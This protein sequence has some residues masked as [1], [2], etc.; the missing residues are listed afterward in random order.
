MN[1]IL[2]LNVI[3]AIWIALDGLERKSDWKLSALLSLFFSIFVYPFYIAKRR[4]SPGEIREGGYGWNV[5]RNF[6]I[7]WTIYLGVALFLAMAKISEMEPAGSNAEEAGRAIGTGLGVG[8]IGMIW[9]FPALGALIL[10]LILKKS[11]I[12]EKS[13]DNQPLTNINLEKKPFYLN[14][15]IVTGTLVFLFLIITVGM[16]SNT[17]LAETANVEKSETEFHEVGQLL[18]FNSLDIQLL[19]FE[20][21]DYVNTGNRFTNLKPEQGNQYV[22]LD[23]SYRNTETSPFRF[24]DTGILTL[25][26][27]GKIYSYDKTETVMLEGWHLL[28]KTLNPMNVYNTKLVYKIPIVPGAGIFWQPLTNS[29]NDIYALGK[30]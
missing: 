21:T 30:L 28:Y 26:I 23:V 20:I 25:F 17:K 24:R 14:K 19:N 15:K 16:D 9:F 13:E 5:V 3:L 11:S 8:I 7:I 10:G 22:I 4:L 1:K 12:I 18:Q 29:T 27:D 6:I 2:L